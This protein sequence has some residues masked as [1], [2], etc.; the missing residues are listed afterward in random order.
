VRDCISLPVA[1]DVDRVN[2]TNWSTDGDSKW[3]GE[4]DVS[5]DGVDAARSG[6]VRD[7][8]QS[9]METEIE[10]P[11]QLLFWWRTSSERSYDKLDFRTRDTV[12][13]E[14]DLPSERVGADFD[15]V[16]GH[17]HLQQT[18]QNPDRWTDGCAK[19]RSS[20]PNG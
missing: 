7:S 19:C 13:L 1:L 4:T 10:G 17:A 8:Q 20:N 3:L 15:S 16:V 12:E 14:R 6:A 2:W 11:G 18:W 5:K 9:W